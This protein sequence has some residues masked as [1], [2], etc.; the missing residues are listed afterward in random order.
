MCLNLPYPP[1]SFKIEALAHRS[2]HSVLRLAPQ[3]FSRAL[4]N[5]VGFCSA[6]DPTPIR[7]YCAAVRYRFAVSE[8]NYLIQLQ[9]DFFKFVGDCA[10]LIRLADIMPHG[11]IDSPS[12]LQCLHDT[13][14]L[15]GPF[16]LPSLNPVNNSILTYPL[17][18]L[19]QGCKGVQTAVIRMLAESEN[20]HNFL[21]RE[22]VKKLRISLGEIFVSVNFQPNW[23]S[24]LK[25]V[26]EES[27]IFLRVCWLKAVGGGWTTSTRM[28]EALALPCIFGCIDCLDE[29]RHYLICPILWQLAREALDMRESSCAVGHRMCLSSVNLNRLKLLGFCH[30]MYHSIRKDSDCFNSDGTIR[31]SAI[32]QWRAC[33]SFRALL[34]LIE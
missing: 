4:T 33:G 2:I 16:V 7:S 12:I 28:H 22:L 15:K 21:E 9:E 23:L 13:L 18:S 29:F 26:F 6:I 8:A 3:T 19:P 14:A 25:E 17:S 27:N 32:V 10:P 1:K 34:P 20:C 11:G 30:L 24:L 31:P 5:T